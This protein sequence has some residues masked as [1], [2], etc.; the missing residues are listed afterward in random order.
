MT[1]LTD[2]LPGSIARIVAASLLV[3]L[4]ATAATM[5]FTWIGFGTPPDWGWLVAMAGWGTTVGAFLALALVARLREGLVS[6]DARKQPGTLWDVITLWPRAVHP[7]APPCY[8]ERSVPEVVFRIRQVTGD[9]LLNETPTSG[10]AKWSPSQDVLATEAGTFW[11]VLPTQTEKVRWGDD[12]ELQEEARRPSCSTGRARVRRS[13]WLSLHSCPPT[14]PG[15]RRCSPWPAPY[16]GCTG[17][18]SPPTTGRA[19][20]TCC[21]SGWRRWRRAARSTVGAT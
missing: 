13:R 21:R 3:L 2:D 19:S 20:W 9:P 5:D 17:A 15:S 11:P 18:P 1:E 10:T 8:A 6:R 12:R 14:R 16:D 4:L 7:L